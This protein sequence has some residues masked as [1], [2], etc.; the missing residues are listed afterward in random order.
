MY[1]NDFLRLKSAEIGYTLPQ[2][3]AAKIKLSSCR[4]YLSGTN[5]LL[6]SNFKIWDVEMG[7]NGLGYPLQRVAN[8]GINLTF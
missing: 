8:L 4:F 5:L 6:F 2:K 1:N 7:G 3:L